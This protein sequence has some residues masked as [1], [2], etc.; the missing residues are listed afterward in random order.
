MREAEIQRILRGRNEA[1]VAREWAFA[2]WVKDLAAWD[3]FFTGTFRNREVTRG[4]FTFEVG[5]S[6][7]SAARAFERWM[8]K[9]L[10]GV[11]MFYGID[12]NP[13]RDGHH[14][15]G[16]LELKGE[17]RR[18]ALWECWWDKHGTNRIMPIES[19]GGVS[20]YCAKYPLTGARWWDFKNFVEVVPTPKPEGELFVNCP[21]RLR[22]RQRECDALW[23][24][25]GRVAKSRSSHVFDKMDVL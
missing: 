1:A 6:E 8:K 14:V 23:Q 24:K 7:P 16:L 2:D 21:D 17:R 18:D 25:W 19:I 9:E 11:R 12:P 10:P 20:G 15:H 22:A 5:R 13:S 4:G 3:T